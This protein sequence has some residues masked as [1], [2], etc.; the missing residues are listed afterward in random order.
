MHGSAFTFGAGEP[1]IFLGLFLLLVPLL[2]V[3]SFVVKEPLLPLLGKIEGLQL[4]AIILLQLEGLLDLL[5]GVISYQLGVC[6]KSHP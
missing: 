4:D 3:V 1:G 6:S 5:Q 2:H